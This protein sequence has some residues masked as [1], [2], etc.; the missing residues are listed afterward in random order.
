[1]KKESSQ[2]LKYQSLSKGLGITGLVLG[3][4]TLLV[5]FIPCF[6]LFTIFFGI[7]AISISL[8]GL[9]ITLK[10]NHE[11]G[12]IVGA[13]ITSLLGCG[14]A[15][16]QYA[17]M[18]ALGDELIK[19][20]NKTIVENGGEPID[21]KKKETKPV[22][23]VIVDDERKA[24]IKKVNYFSDNSSV[25]GENGISYN[26]KVKKVEVARR[27]MY[28]SEGINYVSRYDNIYITISA[29]HVEEA[30][31]LFSNGELKETVNIKGY[32]LKS[33][34]SDGDG[35]GKYCSDSFIFYPELNTQT[36]KK[37]RIADFTGANCGMGEEVNNRVKNERIKAVKA[38]GILSNEDIKPIEKVSKIVNVEAPKT[39]LVEEVSEEKIE[40]NKIYNITVDNLRVRTSPD[41]DAEKIEN[42]PLDTK[43]EFLNQKSEQKI[44]VTI[45]GKEIDEYW[46]KVK[47]PSGNVGWIHGCCFDKN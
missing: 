26:L 34:R 14:I 32:L 36:T 11:K 20:A 43:V 35:Y 38:S 19:E 2:E 6:G 45:K 9:V 41:L 12:L 13:L 40:V 29:F 7:I 44:T 8:I 4:V 17:A 3:I 10:H 27:K 21:F 25:T 5:S 33:S 46:Y 18:N 37:S 39:A 30:F 23:T 1:M 15:Y 24:K 42:L 28:E 31:M 22:S 47:T 16:S